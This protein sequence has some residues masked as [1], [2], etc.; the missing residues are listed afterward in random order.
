[1]CRL[2]RDA[3]TDKIPV[4]ILTGTDNEQELHGAIAGGAKRCLLKDSLQ[5]GEVVL[6][7]EQAAPHPPR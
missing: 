5:L 1:M 2:Q 3:A 4:V 6:A 7:L